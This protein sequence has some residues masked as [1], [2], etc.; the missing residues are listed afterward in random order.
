MINSYE[1]RKRDL[2]TYLK[3]ELWNDVDWILSNYPH[4][5]NEKFVDRFEKAHEG[6][7]YFTKEMIAEKN[8]KRLERRQ[9]RRKNFEEGNGVEVETASASIV[10]IEIADADANADAFK[11]LSSVSDHMAESEYVEN[12]EESDNLVEEETLLS[13]LLDEDNEDDDSSIKDS[14]HVNSY[15]RPESLQ[16]VLENDME[17]TPNM[18][19]G[20]DATIATSSQSSLLSLLANDDD[21]DDDELDDDMI[22][23]T[24]PDMPNDTFSNSSLMSLLDDDRS[25]SKYEVHQSEQTDRKRDEKNRLLALFREMNEDADADANANANERKQK[26]FGKEESFGRSSSSNSKKKSSLLDM[27][28]DDFNDIFGAKD[29]SPSSSSSS[30]L[31][32]GSSE[33]SSASDKNSVDE[34]TSGS[35][36]DLLSDDGPKRKPVEK[37]FSSASLL[38]LMEEDG[39]T[40]SEPLMLSTTKIESRA[41]RNPPTSSVVKDTKKNVYGIDKGKNAKLDL[42]DDSEGSTLTPN[43]Q[44]NPQRSLLDLLDDDDMF[45]TSEPEIEFAAIENDSKG[46]PTHKNSLIDL[47]DDADVFSTSKYSSTS[48]TNDGGDR[49]SSPQ[50]SLLDLLDNDSEASTGEFTPKR[51][52]NALLNNELNDSGT[53]IVSDRSPQNVSLLD[54]LDDDEETMPHNIAISA[55]PGSGQDSLTDLLEIDERIHSGQSQTYQDSLLSLLDSDC[56]DLDSPI[57]S[58]NEENA[59]VDVSKL[60]LEDVLR[61]VQSLISTMGR[62]DWNFLHKMYESMGSEQQISEEEAETHKV[63]NSMLDSSDN[64]TR[65]I[66]FRGDQFIEEL[67]MGSSMGKWN[68]TSNEYNMLLMHVATSNSP[69]KVERLMDIYLH[70]KELSE[71][72]GRLPVLNSDSFSIL[73]AV[74]EKSPGTSALAADICS[75]M[76]DNMKKNLQGSRYDRDN[77]FEF[78]IGEEALEIALRIQARTLNVEE[79]EF[80]ME[81]ALSDFGKG[82]RVKPSVFKTMMLL[83]KSSNKQEEA[84]KL[85]RCCLEE[86]ESDRRLEDFLLQA[87]SWPRNN[88]E[89]KK[90]AVSS[91][92]EAIVDI[93][94]KQDGFKT[95]SYRVWRRLLTFAVYTARESPDNWKLV[96]RCCQALIS[97]R[98][99]SSNSIDDRLLDI[100]LEVAERTRDP[101]IAAEMISNTEISHYDIME[102][103]DND[104]LVFH[105]V[106]EKTG[107]D[108]KFRISPSSYIKAINLC[109]ECGKPS[110]GDKI[111]AHGCKS[112][113]PSSA[114]SDMHTLVL[115]GYARGGDSEKASHVFEQMRLSNLKM[116]ESTYAAYIHGLIAGKRHLDALN[117]LESMLNGSNED[118]VKPG[119][120][121]FTACMMSAM[122]SEAFEDVLV[123][124]KQME[125][126]GIRPNATTFQGVLIANA[127][128]GNTDEL[129]KTIENAINTK[130]PVDANSFLLASKHLMPSIFEESGRDI[131]L[132]RLSLRKQV[133][134]NPEVA[135]EAMTLNRTLTDCLREDQRKPSRMKSEVAIQRLRNNLWREA[136][137]DVIGLSKVLKDN[138]EMK[139]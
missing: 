100:G 28:D 106:E 80:I 68:L 24:R 84:L 126:F 61:R 87:V 109:I 115:T 127:R 121:S 99:W 105:P 7:I 79:A 136:L 67:V 120:S 26:Q 117:L 39:L 91:Y 111:L 36:L 52:F 76:M 47:L 16:T 1:A 57:C 11:T 41:Q 114:L 56:D 86:N 58:A 50:E 45:G 54:L 22:S 55:E 37:Y 93:L 103:I 73:L 138:D 5:R 118:D 53:N 17:C 90:I 34:S 60:K 43:E 2:V 30:T 98:D 49:N 88:R 12:E 116:S 101:Q 48:V 70:M 119:I 25:P 122:Q 33:S 18:G 85:I 44:E 71:S 75:K 96:Q 113:L 72:S 134:M 27:I 32:F 108:R 102:E 46:D 59:K 62:Q 23:A 65:S 42:L 77:S 66:D 63:E 137:K 112:D 20:R 82:V 125:D 132:M 10:P 15:D 107:N 97:H 81:W 78:E 129:V 3:A 29:S 74:F 4:P 83:Y 9:Q 40:T 38:D 31:S 19:H 8:Q 14:N 128:L 92:C 64:F 131:E 94:E 69:N 6:K 110:L 135:D 51:P 21:D 124:N 89:G 133:E 139:L 13:D 95:P 123:L 130:T 104:S 35:L